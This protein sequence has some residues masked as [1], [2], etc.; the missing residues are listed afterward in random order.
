[1]TDRG[2]EEERGR[3]G[4]RQRKTTDR[5]NDGKKYRT[6][7]RDESSFLSSTAT[8]TVAVAGVGNERRRKKGLT[9]P[10]VTLLQVCL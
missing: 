2:R 1:M 10:W 8:A 9:R 6:D 5:G 4:G 7:E 3:E